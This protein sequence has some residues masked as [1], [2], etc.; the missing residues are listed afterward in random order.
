MPDLKPYEWGAL[1]PL[2]VLVIVIGLIPNP[3]LS[4]FHQS[5]AHLVSQV[6]PS[7]VA[8]LH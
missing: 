4:V 8:L 7:P 2:V 6:Q 5:V 3:V 1:L